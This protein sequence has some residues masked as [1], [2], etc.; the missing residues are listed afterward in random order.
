MKWWL[1]ENLENEL[2]LSET[3]NQ[4]SDNT[5]IKGEFLGGLCHEL[6][7]WSR[8]MCAI[9]PIDYLF[10]SFFSRDVYYR[11]SKLSLWM[12]GKKDILL[13][14][15]SVLDCRAINIR[16]GSGSVSEPDPNPFLKYSFYTER[17]IFFVYTELCTV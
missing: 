10:L 9:N 4:Y 13:G 8:G 6:E 5:C 17:K 11:I 1:H 16:Y 12:V 15:Q 2:N 3:L 7:T 14:V